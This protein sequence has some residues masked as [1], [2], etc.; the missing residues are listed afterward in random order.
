MVQGTW[1]TAGLWRACTHAQMHAQKT[2]ALHV[3]HAQGTRTHAHARATRT[4][5]TQL[6]VEG[7]KERLDS[8]EISQPAIYVASLAAVEK[9]RATE[10]QVGAGLGGGQAA[11][12]LALTTELQVDSHSLGA[13]RREATCCPRCQWPP[14]SRPARCCALAV[15]ARRRPWMPL[16]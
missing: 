7:P 5:H 13:C 11:A 4:R 12:A 1:I 3:M 14:A 15:R 6:C 8:T 16:M 9:L 10:G 2:H